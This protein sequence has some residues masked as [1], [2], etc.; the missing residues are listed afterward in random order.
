MHAADMCK[1]WVINTVAF[2]KVQCINAVGTV[3]TVA[4]CGLAKIVHICRFSLKQVQG[5]RMCCCLLIPAC[6]FVELDRCAA[7]A[8][9]GYAVGL[10]K[11][12]S[13]DSMAKNDLLVGLP[14]LPDTAVAGG[15]TGYPSSRTAEVKADVAAQSSGHAG[16]VVR[17]NVLSCFCQCGEALHASGVLFGKGKLCGT[18]APAT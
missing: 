3:H 5:W 17:E 2:A 14:L 4:G 10:F 15:V 18:H 6:R 13:A 9:S 12:L 11:V 16:Q 7:A 1:R 8:E